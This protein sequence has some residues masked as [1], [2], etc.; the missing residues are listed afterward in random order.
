MVL[1]APLIDVDD[2]GDKP[3]GGV[4]QVPFWAGA[5]VIPNE[6]AV[7]ASP[8]QSIHVTRVGLEGLSTSG[9]HELC[10]YFSPGHPFVDRGRRHLSALCC[11]GLEYNL[12]ALL[13]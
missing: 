11:T 7:P 2:E 5:Q 6:T 13:G 12:R 8:R 3:R 9:V 10:L 4:A 1:T